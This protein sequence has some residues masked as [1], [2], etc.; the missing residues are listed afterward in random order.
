VIHAGPDAPSVDVAVKG[1]PILVSGLGFGS[2]A[3]PLPVDAGTY[4]LEVRPA[5]SAQ[6]A[7]A[8]PGVRLE[9][10]KIYTF[11]ATGFI[12]GQP[13]LTVV[14]YVESPVAAPTTPVTPPRTGDAGLANTG[15]SN[16]DYVLYGAL[17]LVAVALSGAAIRIAV[18]R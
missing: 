15:S 7:L 13:T 8:V 18:R 6:V 12:N 10:G 4:D 14:P 11:V 17:A 5:G 16:N 3:G 9:S 2:K 1:G